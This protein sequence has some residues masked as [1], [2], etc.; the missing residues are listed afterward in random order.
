[1]KLVIVESPAKCNTIQKY[2]GDEYIVKASLG[3]IRDLATRGKGG[4]GVEV[5]ND[6]A[7]IYIINKDKKKVVYELKELA[8][9][10]DEVILATD[11]DREGEAIAWHL[12]TVLDLDINTNKRL[13][14][15]EITRE[16]IENA[17]KS[18]R[19]IDLNLVSSQE[20]RRILDR[21]IGFK[22]SALLNRKIHSKSAGRVQSATLKLIADHDIEINNFVPEEYYDI[23]CEILLNNKNVKVTFVSDKDGNKEIKTKD[24]AEKIIKSLGTNFVITKIEKTIKT[25]ESKA[26][27]TTSSLQQEAFAKLKFST[28][29]TSSVAQ[30]LYEGI[31]L[32][33]E[34]AGLITY[35]RTDDSRLSSTYVGRANV[36]IEEK[37]GKEYLGTAKKAKSNGLAQEAHEAIRPTSNHRTPESIR[38]YLTTDQYN[39]YKL[40]YNRTLAS[41]MKPKKEEVLTV[42]LENNGIKFKLTY[43]KTIFP[44]YELVYKYDIEND[45]EFLPSFEENQVLLLASKEAVQKFTNPPSRYSE[46]KVVQLMEEVGIGRPS[47][48]ASTIATLKKRKYVTEEKGLFTVS[49]QGMKTSKVLDKYFPSIVNAQY[50]A[51]M[52]SKLDQIQ[53]GNT[54]SIQILNDFYGPFIKMI[55]DGYRIMYVDEQ[56]ETG[57][58]CPKCGHPLVYKEGRNGKF[59]ACS[60]YP[61]CDYV[62]K[63]IKEVVYIGRNCP[64][65]GKPLVERIKNG[66]KFIACSGYPSCKYH[67][68]LQV[69]NEDGAI[70]KCPKCGSPLVK[71]RGAYGYFLGCSNYPNCN[72][73]E[74]ISR[75]R[76]K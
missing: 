43:T 22:L 53:D 29:K 35:I 76:T 52:E 26:P 58:L 1:M 71:K 45:S 11:P 41:L 40:I 63:T 32:D 27:F 64:Q 67:E 46:A 65:C 61:E 17:M 68:A 60:N 51:E 28:A 9:K 62:Q 38:E 69:T 15:H 24:Q 75:K 4:L 31:S 49:E 47:T 44:G 21:I 74:K 16:S 34:H 12:A 39:L 36:Y 66:K 19:T 42:N 55:E 6:F 8:K 3:H 37:Y 30:M 13:E 18:P 5:D 25:I 23:N 70:K 14:F 2:L 10:A 20:T 59:I 54:T 50:T 72:Y 33:G 73:M 48:Y 7:P 56:E 57:E